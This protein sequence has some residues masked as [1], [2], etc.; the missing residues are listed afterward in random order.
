MG[1]WDTPFQG[2]TYGDAIKLEYVLRAS[3]AMTWIMK[4]V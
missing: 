1:Y 3:K 4:R 2:P